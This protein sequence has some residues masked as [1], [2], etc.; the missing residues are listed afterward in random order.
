MGLCLLVS[1]KLKFDMFD[2]LCVGVGAYV[3]V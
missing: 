2:A 3:C 1:T